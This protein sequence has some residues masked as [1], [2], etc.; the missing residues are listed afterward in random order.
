MRRKLFVILGFLPISFLHLLCCSPAQNTQ[1]PSSNNAS[2]NK[3]ESVNNNSEAPKVVTSESS[4][5]VL[6][7]GQMP[8][9]WSQAQWQKG[10]RERVIELTIA[11]DSDWGQI[12]SD[13]KSSLGLLL[14]YVKG[15]SRGQAA[16]VLGDRKFELPELFVQSVLKIDGG[17]MD[18]MFSSSRRIVSP[19]GQIAPDAIVYILASD[20]LEMQALKKG[21]TVHLRLAPGIYAPDV[22][23]KGAGRI[24]FVLQSTPNSTDPLKGKA[25]SNI[26]ETPVD[27]EH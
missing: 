13:S 20:Q 12:P 14:C 17:G 27:F 25:I 18:F 4:A 15:A 16:K 10:Q 26:I 5:D 8:I 11:Q 7:T 2:A 1:S 22:A 9:K 3:S 19:T 6:I 24:A 23:F 21:K